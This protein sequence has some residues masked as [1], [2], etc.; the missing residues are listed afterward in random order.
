M[1]LDHIVWAVPDLAAGVAEFE[2][3]TGVRPAPGGSHTGVGTANHLVGLGG[4]SYLEV[5]GPDPAQ[6]E[7]AAPRPFGLD[8]LTAPRVVTWC[9]RP[10]DLDAAI[11]A[12][13][14]GGYDPGPPRS[15][16]R[17]RPDGVVLSWRLTQSGA[18]PDAGLVPFLID[19]QDSVHPT[20]GDLPVVGL[21][22]MYAEHPDPPA[23]RARLAPL[24]LDLDVRPGTAPRLVVVLDTPHGRVGL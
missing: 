17:R 4:S 5:I 15:M 13:V 22:E 3:R 20:R 1:A 14:A 16:S 10:H 11:A 23:V 19:W 12:A 6:P 18:D 24:D 7:P 8:A 9:V 21:A 2:R